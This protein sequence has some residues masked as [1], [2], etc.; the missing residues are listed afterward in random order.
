MRPCTLIAVAIASALL[1]GCG[2]DDAPSSANS[3]VVTPTP[4]TLSLSDRSSR[5]RLTA[6]VL[7]Y[8]AASTSLRSG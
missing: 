3:A 8:G 1:A 6:N 7:A 2:T 4:A 5:N